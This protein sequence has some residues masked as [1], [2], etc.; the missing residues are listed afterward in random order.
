MLFSAEERQL[1]WTTT[2]RVW[3]QDHPPASNNIIRGEDKFPLVRPNWH[4]NNQA[5]RENME[6]LRNMIIL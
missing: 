6:D 4:N 5:H 2:I 1:I 3:E